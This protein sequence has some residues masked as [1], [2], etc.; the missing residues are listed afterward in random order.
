[1]SSKKSAV[2]KVLRSSLIPFKKRKGRPNRTSGPAAKII[3]ISEG[4]YPTMVK[5]F[6]RKMT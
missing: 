1:M 2:L 3:P 6:G 5:T 4:V